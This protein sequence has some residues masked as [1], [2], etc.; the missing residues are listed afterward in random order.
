MVFTSYPGSQAALGL[1]NRR[2]SKPGDPTAAGPW[3]SICARRVRSPTRSGAA[4]PAIEASRI[5]AFV[6]VHIEQARAW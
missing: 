6:E 4:L 1:L 3:P 5:A 2:R